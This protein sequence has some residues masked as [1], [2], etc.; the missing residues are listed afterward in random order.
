M[1]PVFK[2][3]GLVFVQILQLC[4]PILVGACVQDHVVRSLDRVDAVKLYVTQ[5]MDQ[6]FELFGVK[7]AGRCITQPLSRQQQMARVFV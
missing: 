7:R 1:G 5:L 4:V 3:A 2:Q 6:G